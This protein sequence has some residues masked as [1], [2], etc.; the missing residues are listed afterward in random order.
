MDYHLNTVLLRK[1]AKELEVSNLCRQTLTV[2]WVKSL[3]G[4]STE[5]PEK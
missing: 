5:S 1:E 2:R 4:Q 3:P